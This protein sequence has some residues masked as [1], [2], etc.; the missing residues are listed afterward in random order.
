MTTFGLEPDLMT[1][2]SLTVKAKSMAFYDIYEVFSAEGFHVL[3]LK[4]ET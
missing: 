4:E 2:L 3:F 1:T